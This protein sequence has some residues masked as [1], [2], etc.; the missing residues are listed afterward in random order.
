MRLAGAGARRVHPISGHR[1]TRLACPLCAKSRLMHRSQ[2]CRIH[3]LGS[4]SFFSLPD[5]GEADSILSLRFS[6]SSVKQID[7]WQKTAGCYFTPASPCAWAG[8]RAARRPRGGVTPPTPRW[9]ARGNSDR[10]SCQCNSDVSGKAFVLPVD[11]GAACR[12]EIKG[13]RVA[14][15]GCPHPR[16]SFTGDGDLLTGEARLVANHGAGAALA[17][18]AVAHRD[19]RWF[20]LNRKMKLPAGTGGAS[21]HRSAPWLSTC[22]SN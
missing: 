8:C 9:S 6:G 7:T 19:A 21:C 2:D 4:L 17:L 18:Q 5:F 10:R 14:A 1:P 16:R 15:F 22:V 11:G 12:A 3:G 13:K 20:A